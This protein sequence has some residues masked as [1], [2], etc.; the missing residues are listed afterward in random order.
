MTLWRLILAFIALSYAGFGFAFISKPDAMAAMISIV[1]A[2]AAGRT[3]FRATYGGLEFGLGVFLLLCAFRGEFVRVGLFAAAC[4]LLAMA[5]ARTMGLVL[6]GFAF[7]QLVIA[8]SEWA[9]GALAAWG[10]LLARP[11]PDALPP[12]LED[13][14]PDDAPLP[15]AA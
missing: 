15:P 14:T 10:A 13:P 2:D 5:T 12:P 6:D 3:D 11:A 9:G 1:P 4:A 7:L 8:M